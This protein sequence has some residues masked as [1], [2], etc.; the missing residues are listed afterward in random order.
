MS[1]ERH[2]YQFGTDFE[3]MLKKARYYFRHATRS[4]QYEIPVFKFRITQTYSTMV[5]IPYI[6]PLRPLKAIMIFSGLIL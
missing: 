1:P 4:K 5:L 6:H 3:S 2:Q